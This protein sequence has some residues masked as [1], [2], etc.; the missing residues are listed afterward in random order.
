MLS[1]C[2]LAAP[3]AAGEKSPK[4][5]KKNSNLNYSL[6][7]KETICPECGMLAA[8]CPFSELPV[9]LGEDGSL[10]KFIAK[11]AVYPQDA[12]DINK[13]GRVKCTFV[14]D[15]TGKIKDI[16]VVESAHLLLAGEAVKI[17]QEQ[18]DW[19]P[20]LRHGVPIGTRINISIQF[21]L[22]GGLR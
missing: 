19:E 21:K 14:V 8:E 2:L 5:K 9:F 22:H 11:R 7:S 10:S 17:L 16:K 1:V 12:F 3:S 18:P 13:E 4:K 20:G 15:E 6:V